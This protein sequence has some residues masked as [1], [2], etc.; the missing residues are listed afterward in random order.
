MTNVS[1]W[2]WR[3]NRLTICLQIHVNQSFFLIVF[4]CVSLVW[5]YNLL[6]VAH[7]SINVV[8][9]LFCHINHTRVTLDYFDCRTLSTTAKR[10]CIL[11]VYMMS[12]IFSESQHLFRLTKK[13][14]LKVNPKMKHN[15][16]EL[17]KGQ[18]DWGLVRVPK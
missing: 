11:F 15:L 16:N 3:Y 2:Y 4:P 7:L 18:S 1:R 17:K 9:Q 14:L 12:R 13:K 10:I 8:S 6:G 5:F